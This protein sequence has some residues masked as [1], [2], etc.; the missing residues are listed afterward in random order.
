MVVVLGLELRVVH[1]QLWPPMCIAYFSA[2]DL[3]GRY[4]CVRQ[5][6]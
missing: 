3:L 1:Q 4:L 5:D 6:I 2:V